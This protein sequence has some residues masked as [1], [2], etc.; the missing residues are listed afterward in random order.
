MLGGLLNYNVNGDL[1]NLFAS[2]LRT[3]L[4]EGDGKQPVR[5]F[6]DFLRQLGAKKP[7]RVPGFEGEVLS[8]LTG[9]D[10][11]RIK[12][13]ADG[14]PPRPVN[15]YAHRRDN[16]DL[17]GSLRTME[18]RNGMVWENG[19][20]R[21]RTP[22]DRAPEGLR[23]LSEDGDGDGKGGGKLAAAGEPEADPISGNQPSDEQA[24]TEQEHKKA[25]PVIKMERERLQ[26]ILD[27]K[28]ARFEVADNPNVSG[29][30][31]FHEA[32]SKGYRSF[33][34]YDEIVQRMAKNTI[35][36]KI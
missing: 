8:K 18:Q 19:K 27:D 22:T 15:A 14:P 25:I 33:V 2:A 5:E 17:L 31:K 12:R 9:A 10:R 6:A 34:K 11:D 21:A 20:W 4:S 35:W 29:E 23:L 1:P 13:L 3:G 7:D 26:S 36:I 24:P 16:D 28:P 32:P 30:E